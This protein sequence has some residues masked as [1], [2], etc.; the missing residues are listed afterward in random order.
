VRRILPQRLAKRSQP[1][2]FGR[3][4][5]CHADAGEGA[6]QAV[7]CIGIG[8]T[9]FRQEIDAAYLV[10]K[11]VGNAEACSRARRMRLRE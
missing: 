7:E 3:C 5:L 9:V 1:K 4:L 6:Q 8:L 2:V 10:S 11:S